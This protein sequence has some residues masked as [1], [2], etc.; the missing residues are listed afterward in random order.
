MS[1]RHT[2]ERAHLCFGCGKQIESGEPHIHV[3]L[4]EWSASQGMDTFGLDD[5]LTFPFCSEC[6]EDSERGWTPET[7]EIEAA[8]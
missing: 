5:L 1:D 2:P 4:D 7:H 3:G 6:I 8:T